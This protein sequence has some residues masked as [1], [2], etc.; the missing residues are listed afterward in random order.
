MVTLLGDEV[1]D[2]YSGI[3]LA[4]EEYPFMY[5]LVAGGFIQLFPIGLKRGWKTPEGMISEYGTFIR[6]GPIF[7]STEA[8]YAPGDDGGPARAQ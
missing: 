8:V 2:S 6:E 7:I 5:I 1:L 4:G 3:Y